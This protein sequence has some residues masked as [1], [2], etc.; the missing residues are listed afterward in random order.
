VRYEYG[1][2]YLGLTA[3]LAIMSYEAHALL[4]HGS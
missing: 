4:Q 2:M 1:I 3:F